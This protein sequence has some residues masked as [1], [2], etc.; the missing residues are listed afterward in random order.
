MQV[1]APL[2]PEAV[3]SPAD[4]EKLRQRQN[5]GI[6]P[7]ASKILESLDWQAPFLRQS[8]VRAV[9]LDWCDEFDRFV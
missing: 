8:A 4:E 2:P 7:K 9:Q 1:D 6:H 3:W 5:S